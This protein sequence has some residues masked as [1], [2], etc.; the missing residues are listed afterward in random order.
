MRP[1]WI[2]FT[3]RISGCVEAVNAKA[4]MKIAAKA[5]GAEPVG[6]DRI[7]YP[8][9]PRINVFKYPEHGACP[10]LCYSPERC[11]G[12]TSCPKSYACSE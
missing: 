11:R 1:Y 9:E 2:R 8:A 7:P 4:A 3:G 12:K 10:S 5:T 6:A